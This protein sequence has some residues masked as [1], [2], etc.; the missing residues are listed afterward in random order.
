MGTAMSNRASSDPDISIRPSFEETRRMV[1][2]AA[3]LQLSR[4]EGVDVDVPWAP[5][6]ERDP[7]AFDRPTA[8]APFW[9]ESIQK[10]RRAPAVQIEE[11]EPRQTTPS[12][13]RFSEDVRSGRRRLFAAICAA[14]LVSGGF[15]VARVFAADVVVAE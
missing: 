15:G 3:L 9:V 2:P 12:V 7:L 6:I 4:D 10:T 11:P 1:P 14:L 5:M 13:V 8:P